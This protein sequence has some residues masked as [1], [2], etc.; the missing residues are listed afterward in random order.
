MM[1]TKTMTMKRAQKGLSKMNVS[2]DF[3]FE[4]RNCD[5]KRQRYLV[6]SRCEERISKYYETNP[7]QTLD[8]VFRVF[9]RRFARGC[10]IYG[11]K[12]FVR[13]RHLD[14][15]SYSISF[16]V[17]QF[18]HSKKK[19]Y[20]QKH[21]EKKEITYAVISDDDLDVFQIPMII[22][23]TVLHPGPP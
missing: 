21:E 16:I 20:Q 9:V 2:R 12:Q 1:A 10:V 14:K 8:Q 19:S 7:S 4:L 22:I 13:G 17:N 18:L 5:M 6:Q 23:M 15:G 11:G 3:N